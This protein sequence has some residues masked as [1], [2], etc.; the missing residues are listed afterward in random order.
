M[1]A[2]VARLAGFIGSALARFFPWLFTS[3]KG[4]WVWLVA[5]LAANFGKIWESIR[6]YIGGWKAWSVA[7]PLAAGAAILSL[8]VILNEALSIYITQIPIREYI[9][10]EILGDG[11]LAMWGKVAC[12]C[13]NAD[14]FFFY[15]AK[16][17][18]VTLAIYAVRGAFAIA[19]GILGSVTS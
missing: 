9:T 19:R 11:K 17:V 6:K 3:L 14:G 7:I 2:W 18:S 12:Y 4:L 8:S 10:Y 1:W 15:V 16:L 13:I 5:F